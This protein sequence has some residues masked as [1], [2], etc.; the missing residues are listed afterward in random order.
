MAEVEAFVPDNVGETAC[1]VVTEQHNLQCHICKYVMNNPMLLS[2]CGEHLCKSCVDKIQQSRMVEMR[3]CPFCKQEFTCLLNKSVQRETFQLVVKCP[4]RSEGC[5][6]KGKLR[7]VLQHTENTCLFEVVSCPIDGCPAKVLRKNLQKHKEECDFRQY[8]CKFCYDVTDT[9]LK[10]SR[11]HFPVCSD[12]TVPCPNKCD[13]GYMTRASV[14]EHLRDSCP[15]EEVQCDYASAGCRGKCLRKDMA[16]HYETF[17]QHHNKLLLSQNAALQAKLAEQGEQ[18]ARAAKQQTEQSSQFEELL[19]QQETKHEQRLAQ[20][21]EKVTGFT[22]REDQ[23]SS[24][25]EALSVEVKMELM[26]KVA[27]MESNFVAENNELRN[28]FAG[29]TTELYCLKDRHDQMQ[30][31][32]DDL[33]SVVEV[34]AQSAQSFSQLGDGLT[35]LQL[36]QADN[37]ESAVVQHLS[38]TLTTLNDVVGKMADIESQLGTV[39]KDVQYAEKIVTPQPP[40]SFT[41]SRFSERKTNKEPFVSPPF[42]T[43]HRGYKLCV[44]V[45]LHG[46]NSHIAVHCCVMRGEH[47]EH[48][49]WP[50]RGDVHVRIQN[51]L[52][53]HTHFEAAIQYDAATADNKCRRVITGDKNYL[54]GLSQFIPHVQLGLLP[55]K[56]C[57]YL[58]GDAIDFE[59]I[60]VDIQ[61]SQR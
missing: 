50:F 42:Y 39:H 18:L 36:E 34:V 21:E 29:L 10:V 57:Q 25:A 12:Y 59:V 2:C 24:M 48:L 54:H 13:I 6:W 41:V 53:D 23:A 35:A 17:S 43:H 56:N 40:F 52:G 19:R 61:S 5:P 20:L 38:P 3:C 16:I 33:A 45:D 55:A 8:T 30:K 32:V 58:K 28:G 46:M 1:A 47:D 7:D 11:E 15:L 26:D 27:M 4:N 37:I 49:P 31:R 44:R 60:K 14:A 51:Q 22:S 9:Y